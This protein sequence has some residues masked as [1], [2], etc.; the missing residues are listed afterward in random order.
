MTETMNPKMETKVESKELVS[1]LQKNQERWRV[2]NGQEVTPKTLNVLGGQEEVD[3]VKS[4]WEKQ[5]SGAGFDKTGEE[6]EALGGA[7]NVIKLEKLSNYSQ[8][9]G[10]IDRAEGGIVDPEVPIIEDR[11]K[12]VYKVVNGFEWE[13][14]DENEKK[15]LGDESYVELARSGWDKQSQKE[16]TGALKSAE[17]LMALT[18]RKGAAGIEDLVNDMAKMTNYNGQLMEN[19]TKLNELFDLRKKIEEKYDLSQEEKDILNPPKE[20]EDKEP[21]FREG[22]E[23]DEEKPDADDEDGG[24]EKAEGGDKKPEDGGGGLPKLDDEDEGGKKPDDE[25]GLPKLDDEREDEPVVVESWTDD[26]D[27]EPV[28]EGEGG[29][30]DLTEKFERYFELVGRKTPLSEE[31]KSERDG[32]F[33]LVAANREKY[34]DWRNKGEGDDGEDKEPEVEPVIVDLVD[35]SEDK[36]PKKVKKEKESKVKKEKEPREKRGFWASIKR[37]FT[38]GTFSEPTVVEINRLSDNFGERIKQVLTANDVSRV[39]EYKSYASLDELQAAVKS[40]EHKYKYVENVTELMSE[41][42]KLEIKA[43]KLLNQAEA[44]RRK[45]RLKR[46]AAE[47]ISRNN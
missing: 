15:L 19:G 16:G 45:A 38:E 30:E 28:V 34:Q 47:T 40:G 29:S 8:E 18:G 6:L 31:E 5:K 24:G 3:L 35:K 1:S 13:D 11:N 27:K 12:V 10:T 9:M 33:A 43:E 17:E 20:N 32:L 22:W 37:F 26:G 23:N 42:D 14:L 39:R 25:G 21:E 2:I 46:E 44:K 36:E 41:A 7:V 4:G